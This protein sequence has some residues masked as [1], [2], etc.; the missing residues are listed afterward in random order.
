MASLDG[1]RI[2]HLLAESKVVRVLDDQSVALRIVYSGASTSAPVISVITAASMTLTTSLGATVFTFAT[3]ST[4]TL[5]AAAINAGIGDGG[6]SGAGAGFSCRILDAIPS[7]I[8]TAS[9][10]VASAG[11]VASSVYGE[12]V[13]DALMDTSTSKNVCFRVSN[14]RNIVAKKARGG[15]RVKLVG[16]SYNENVSAGEAAAVRVY[17]FNSVDKSTNLVWAALSVDATITAI[18]F[19]DAPLTA[20]EG[21][22]LIVMVSDGTSLTDA[23]ANFLQVSFIRE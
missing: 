7:Q 11:L 16:F 9:N 23:A 21:N 1:L 5:L 14:D 20:S 12:M 3:F 18:D 6:L 13:Y 2:R 10:I 8:T 4:L 22:E 19:S 15:H 17:E